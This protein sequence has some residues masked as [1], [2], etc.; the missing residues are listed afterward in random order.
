MSR[1]SK[2]K[3]PALYWEDGAVACPTHFPSSARVLG[4]HSVSI[5]ACRLLYQPQQSQIDMSYFWEW[6]AYGGSWQESVRA[7]RLGQERPK[8][9]GPGN[10]QHQWKSSS[11]ETKGMRTELDRSELLQQSGANAGDALKWTPWSKLPLDMMW[12]LISGWSRLCVG[13]KAVT[14]AAHELTASSAHFSW[15]ISIGGVEAK[16]VSP[17]FICWRVV[18][19]GRCRTDR[20]HY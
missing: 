9:H 17:A 8:H 4:S 1:R 5:K 20:I 3:S 2:S 7:V 13:A 12:S 14:A 11:F 16:S 18:V 19:Q 6:W 10:Q 15:Q